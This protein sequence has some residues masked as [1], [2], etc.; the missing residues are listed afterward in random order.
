M[1][2]LQGS[3][4]TSPPPSHYRTGAIIEASGEF[5]VVVISVSPR[6]YVCAGWIRAPRA[7]G[8]QDWGAGHVAD[9]FSHE[10][11]LWEGVLTDYEEAL[12]MRMMLAGKT[13]KP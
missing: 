12:A 1:A 2:K 3:T 7:Y 11:P 9:N 13:V 10:C 4:P 8:M 5:P 6:H